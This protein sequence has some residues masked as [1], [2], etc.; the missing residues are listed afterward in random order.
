MVQW[1]TWW[2]NPNRPLVKGYENKHR[3]SRVGGW[4]L[5]LFLSCLFRSSNITGNWLLLT[6]GSLPDNAEEKAVQPYRNRPG[7]PSKLVRTSDQSRPGWDEVGAGPFLTFQGPS[8]K[9]DI[10]THPHIYI[11]IHILSNIWHIKIIMH[12]F[13]VYKITNVKYSKK[14]MLSH[15]IKNIF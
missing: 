7:R 6:C 4:G 3:N 9:S 1:I 12:Y 8:A 2:L 15:I 5:D 10:E 11:I 14:H 13:E